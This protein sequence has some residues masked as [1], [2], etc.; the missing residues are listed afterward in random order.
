MF[1]LEDDDRRRLARELYDT[2]AQDAVALIMDLVQVIDKYPSEVR[3]DF[4]ECLSL[5]RQHLHDIIMFCH[6]LHPPMLGELGLPS[7][8]RI[9]IEALTRSTG[10]RVELEVPDPCTKLPAEL[11]ITLFRVV[12]ESLTSA[13]KHL[14]TPWSKVRIDVEAAEA[15]VSI[16]SELTADFWSRKSVQESSEM[17]SGIRSIQERVQRLGGQIALHADEYRSVVEA[18]LPLSRAASASTA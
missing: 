2:I 3:A 14:N 1:N 12:L 5:A 17:E 13:R 11:E 4:S 18:I 6:Q 15:K 9:Y 16:E 8:L 10:M 7:A